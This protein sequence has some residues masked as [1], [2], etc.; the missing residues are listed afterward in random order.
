MHDIMSIDNIPDW[1]KRIARTD[2]FWDREIID[3]AVVEI[4]VPKDRKLAPLPDASG[5]STIRDRWISAHYVAESAVAWT[6]NLEY[7][8]DALPVA[9]PN[10]GPDLISAFLGGELEFA[11]TTSWSAPVVREWSDADRIAFS[12]DNFY[13][14]KTLELTDALLDAGRG[15][16]YT[17][18]T[19][20]HTGGDGIAAL[21]GPEKLNYDLIENPDKVKALREKVDRIYMGI[22]DSFHER[23]VSARQPVTTWAPI[24]ST[25]KW[26]IVSNDFS[27]MI[28]KEMYD[29]VFLP[30]IIDECRFLDASLYHLDGPGA[31]RHLD[32][33]LAIDE[34][35]AIQWV[36]GEGNGSASDW[37][38]LYRRIQDAGK[39]LQ[40]FLSADEIDLFMEN[41][42][43]EGLW[44]GVHGVEDA[45]TAETVVRRIST[46]T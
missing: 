21:R 9:W 24:V 36:P 46:W 20:F 6:A 39:G 41:L 10:L 37:I 32:S 45:K 8:G 38:H 5:F 28:S 11:E 25:R 3:R 19:D 43:P 13:Y 7:Y 18:L 22:F 26:G 40:I 44:L 31:L 1:E 2:A 17:G 23:L 4:T 30:G 35:N 14:R 27:C 42:R 29:D 34:L 33:I 12:E 15:R 16:F